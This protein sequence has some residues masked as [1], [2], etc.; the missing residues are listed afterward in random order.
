MSAKIPANRPPFGME[1]YDSGALNEQQQQQLNELKISKRVE[2]EQY[3]RAH[4]EVDA[5]LQ[6]FLK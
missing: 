5:L 4:P 6:E 1:A 2:N 3:L